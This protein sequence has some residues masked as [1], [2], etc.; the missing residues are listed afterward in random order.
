MTETAVRALLIRAT[1]DRPPDIDL[2]TAV[3]AAP[4][5][6]ERRRSRVLVPLGVAAAVVLAVSVTV[7]ALPVGQ[8]SAQAQVVAAVENTSRQSYRVHGSSG[9][10]AF[11]G[12]FDP[13]QRVGVITAVGEDAETRFIGDLMYVRQGGTTWEVSPRMEVADAPLAAAVIKLVIP[14]PAQTLQRLR[15]A[16]SFRK[17][18]A[19]SGDGWTGTRFIFSLTDKG[20]PKAAGSSRTIAGAVDV[21]D[22]DRIRRVQLDFVDSGTRNVITFG[23]FGVPVTVTAPPASEVEPPAGKQSDK[24]AHSSEKPRK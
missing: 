18:G 21:D 24:A 5:G 1:E 7:L 19:A 2:M 3:P 13:V 20:D 9:T 6:R 14:D 23:D 12:A 4:A 8:P 15:S 11:E 16:T 22:Q 17:D 10:R